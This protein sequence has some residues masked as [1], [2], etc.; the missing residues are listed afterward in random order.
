MFPLPSTSWTFPLLDQLLPLWSRHFGYAL[1]SST[2]IHAMAWRVKVA[3][4]VMEHGPADSGLDSLPLSACEGPTSKAL[5][6]LSIVLTVS[7]GLQGSSTSNAISRPLVI[8]LWPQGCQSS[9]SLW[10][11]HRLKSLAHLTSHPGSWNEMKWSSQERIGS[12]QAS[13]FD[14]YTANVKVVSIGLTASC[15]R[16][17]KQKKLFKGHDN[18]SCPDFW[19]Q[20]IVFFDKTVKLIICGVIN[21]GL[22]CV[23][24]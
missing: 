23:I 15:L 22:G 4:L 18:I 14:R 8:F 5:E 7:S 19:L 6:Q 2:S 9:V 24:W 13:E 16:Q 10:L 1:L 21:W 20:K 11:M 12:I 3:G 17:K